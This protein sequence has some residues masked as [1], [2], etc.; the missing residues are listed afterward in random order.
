[1][2]KQIIHLFIC[3]GIIT[4]LIPVPKPEPPVENDVTPQCILE[5]ELESQ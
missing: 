4:S 1:M 5:Y 2:K 3:L